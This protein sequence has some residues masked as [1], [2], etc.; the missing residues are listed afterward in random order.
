MRT[1]G[2]LRHSTWDGWL[3]ALSFVHGAALV[4]APSWPLV[5]LGLWW[6]ANTVSHNFLHLPFF[7]SRRLNAAY[8]AYLTALLGF[9]QSLW[10]AR[11]LAHHAG[12]DGEP[13]PWTTRMRGELVLVVVLWAVVATIAP[14]MFF[15]AYLPGY[16][17]GLTLCAL[18]GHY[19]HARGT[20]SHYG[21]AY[22]LAFFN[23]GFH[24][25]H[26]DRPGV[27]WTQL[28]LRGRTDPQAS[29]WPPVLRWLERV[30][31]VAAA[32]NALERVVI[33]VPALQRFVLRRHEAAFRACLQGVSNVRH[34][35]VIGGGLFPRTALVLQRI[36]P[37]VRLTLVD[38]DGGHLDVARRF[39]GSDIATMH[40]AF[41]PAHADGADLVV[42]PLAYVGDRELFYARPAAPLTLV[43]E[44]AWSVR[45]RGA[46]VSWLLLKRVNLVRRTADALRLSA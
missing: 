17:L 44:W 16:L 38:S 19:E 12:R 27:H 22:N 36:L 46:I 10:R 37:G 8:S 9:P 23:D 1:A 41:E 15:L 28:P 5:A 35:T 43:H 13:L 3:V 31:N 7:R 42:V 34:V 30:A 45:G 18:Q 33:R 29:R 32:L 39:L 20:T 2:L 24:K 40:S 4:A 11:H 21:R 6:N 26:H 14:R 25:E